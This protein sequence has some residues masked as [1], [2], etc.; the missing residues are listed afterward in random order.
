MR[1]NSIVQYASKSKYMHHRT[2]GHHLIIRS[3]LPPLLLLF[4]LWL[5]GNCLRGA[6]AAL[7]MEMG[8]KQ[9]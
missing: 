6:T 4:L 3:L 7:V 5:L 9:C 1:K 2:T 8:E